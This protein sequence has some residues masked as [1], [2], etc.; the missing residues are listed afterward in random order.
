[1]NLDIAGIAGVF[2]GSQNRHWIEGEIGVLGKVF[3]FLLC[4]VDDG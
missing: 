1:M 3:C 4:W 2:S